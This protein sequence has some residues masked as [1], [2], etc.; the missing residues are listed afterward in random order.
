MLERQLLGSYKVFEVWRQV[1][2]HPVTGASVE[3]FQVASGTWVNV[4]PLTADGRVVMVK[5][6][7]FG[8]SEVTLEVPGGLVEPGEAPA[9]AAERELLEETG[10]SA[11]RFVLLGRV[12]P[13]PA[14]HPNWCYSFLAEGAW[15]SDEQD[16]DENEVVDVVHV[17]LEDV[18]ALTWRGAI[19]HSL[20]LAAFHH[21]DLY[22][23]FGEPRGHA[24]TPAGT[25]KGSP[26]Q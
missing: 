19:N 3:T 25:F 26:R 2:R 17:P 21:L 14:L 18:P 10:Y 5:Q 12:R 1:Y 6:F 13:N 4:I 24:S 23:R 7:R 20:V 15:R 8:A 22:R 16:L 11:K 9:A